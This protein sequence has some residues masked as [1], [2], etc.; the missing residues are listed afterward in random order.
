LP[1]TS[2]D[3]ST[4]AIIIS[5]S[6]QSEQQQ[7]HQR[8]QKINNTILDESKM[9]R[10]MECDSSVPSPPSKRED[11]EEKEDRLDKKERSEEMMKKN[12]DE[13]EHMDAEGLKKFY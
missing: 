3:N 5:P 12:D 7:N 11:D 4:S 10:L 13:N 6:P 2:L 1:I 9:T 8:H